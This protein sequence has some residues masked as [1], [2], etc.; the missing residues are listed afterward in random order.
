L[1]GVN[2]FVGVVSLTATASPSTGLSCTLSPISVVGSGNSALSCPSSASGTFTVTI[3]GT[4]GSLSHSVTITI[5]VDKA[6]PS[7]TTTLSVSTI[8]VGGS[9]SDSAVL[10]NGFE[11]GGTVTYEYFTGSSCSGT[12]TTVGG[13]VGVTAGS[14]PNSASQKF[15]SAGSFS[16]EAIYSGDSNNSGATSACA[17]L[18]VMSPP[19]LRIPGT[20]TVTAGSTIQFHVNATGVGGCN[21]VTLTPSNLPA[22]ATFLSTQCFAG[23]ASSV[24][25]WTPTDSQ[26]S[27]DYT[28]TFTAKDAR[29]AVSSAQVTI[30]VSPVNKAA[31]LPILSYSVFGI[32]GFSAVVAVALVLRRIQTTRR[33]P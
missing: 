32:V 9:A 25:S 12:P 11:A 3:I 27:S 6:T 29:G 23:S 1:A 17:N 18:T 19:A 4:S 30:H 33:K 16:W 26:A 28:V 31:P 8:L 22:G 20:Q 2:G 15:N 13:Q 14:V 7:L 5:S 24:F 10:T 21:G